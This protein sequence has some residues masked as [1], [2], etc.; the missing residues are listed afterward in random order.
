MD[1]SHGIGASRSSDQASA[2]YPGLVL[3]SHPGARSARAGLA[4][5]GTGVWI[6]VTRKRRGVERHVSASKTDHLALH[7]QAFR[8]V[9]PACSHSPSSSSKRRHITERLGERRRPVSDRLGERLSASTPPQRSPEGSPRRVT[10]RGRSPPP[11]WHSRVRSPGI[12]YPV[13]L[14]GKATGVQE[15]PAPEDAG[16]AASGAGAAQAVL[17]PMAPAEAAAGATAVSD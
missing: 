17:I 10:G 5:E 4:E 14:M 7:Q 15:E 6:T 11:T 2:A 9:S 3:A 16:E 13:C 1:S 12:T 8:P